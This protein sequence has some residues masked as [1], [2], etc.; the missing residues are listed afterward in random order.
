MKKRGYLLILLI[1]ITLII[2]CTQAPE[3]I[4][5]IVEEPLVE[6]EIIPPEPAD[7]KIETQVEEVK[8]VVPEPIPEK[9]I[10]PN[11]VAHWT[12]DQDAQDS[13]KNNHGT[14]K[15]GATI[16]DGKIGKALY[17][18]GVDDFVD[19]PQSTVEKIGSLGQGTIAFWFNY[20]S[21]LDKQTIM[22]LFYIGMASGDDNMYLIEIGH[23]AGT[24]GPPFGNFPD[25][26]PD[27]NN[28]MIYSTWVKNNQEPFLCF[29]SNKN[30][31]ENKWYH[32]AVVVGPDGNTGYLNGLAIANKDHNFGNPKAQSFLNSII[33]Q[34]KLTLGY[35]KSAY[36]I[37][38]DFEYFKGYI[39]DVR[40]YDRPLNAVEISKLTS[41]S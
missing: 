17:F 3:E 39:D 32:Y 16:K 33:V 24:E 36:Q 20:Q 28:K 8:E 27:P 12:F 11:L 41:L 21:L 22:P 23:A 4:P 19:F 15:G 31:E 38:P 40:I 1:T 18:D 35:G 37:S 9:D 7:I 14:I 13:A 30:L 34:E 6:E 26:T 5:V 25:G 10:D 2:G 29:D